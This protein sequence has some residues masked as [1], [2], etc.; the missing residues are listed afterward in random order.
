AAVKDYE[1]KRASATAGTAA[2]LEKSATA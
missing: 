1:A 2:T